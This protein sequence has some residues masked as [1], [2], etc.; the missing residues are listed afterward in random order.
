VRQTILL[1]IIFMTFLFSS[2]KGENFTLIE[3]NRSEIKI[4][5]N[6]GKYE[7]KNINN[8]SIIDASQLVNTHELGLPELPQFSTT[9]QVDPMYNYDVSFNIIESHVLDNI[10]IYPHQGLDPQMLREEVIVDTTYFSNHNIY[11]SEN[12]VVS[13]SQNMRGMS[14]VS[15]TLIPFKYNDANDLI[16]FDNVEIIV[17]QKDRNDNSYSSK[18]ASRV[19]ANLAENLALNSILLEREENYQQPAIL[20]ICGGNSESN[21]SFQQ[22]VNWRHER[23]YIVYT[24]DTNE[25]GTSSFT[26]KNYIQNAYETFSPPPEYVCL[27][28]DVGGSYSL[29]TFYASWGHDYYGDWCEGDLS[30][31]QL[32]GPDLLPEVIVGRLS[33]RSSNDIQNVVNKIINYEKAT[34]FDYMADYYERSALIGDPSDSGQSTIITNEYVEDV[35]SSHGMSDIRTNFGV[36]NYA[37]WMQNQLSDGVLYFNYRGFAGVSGFTSANIY[38]ANSGHKLPFATVLT[39]LT[40]SFAEET[41]CLS[42]Y[43]LRAGSG[44]NPKGA[45]AAVSTATGNTHTMFNNIVDMGIYDG[46]FANQVGTA[47]AALANGKL[48]LLNAYPD[49]PDNWINAFT[50]WNNLMGDPAT[51]LWTDTPDAIEVVH[52]NE[53]PFGESEIHISILHHSP[54]FVTLT[55]GDEIFTSKYSQLIDNQIASFDIDYITTGEITITV[56][57]ENVI[58]YQSIINIVQAENYVDIDSASEILIEDGNDGTLNPGETFTLMVPVMNY[59]TQI[60]NNVNVQIIAYDE[61]LVLL[62]PN[63]SN[64]GSIEPNSMSYGS[65]FDF[66]LLPNLMHGENVY[67]EVEITD[68]FGIYNSSLIYLDVF[69]VALKPSTELVLDMETSYFKIPLMNLGAVESVEVTATLSCLNENIVIENAISSWD[70]ILP[71]EI[72]DSNSEFAISTQGNIINGSF[73]SFA[74]EIMAENGYHQNESFS[75]Q[76]GESLVTDPLGPDEYGYYIYDMGDTNYDLAPTYNWVE[77]STNEGGNGTPLN[78]SDNGNGIYSNSSEI[79]DLPFS[80]QFYG[81]DYDKITVCTNGWIAF[82]ESNLE[83]FRNYPVPGAGG[84]SAMIAAFW[85]D[86]YTT[87]NADVFVYHDMLNDDFIIEWYRMKNFME[88]D[89]QTFQIILHQNIDSNIDNN[90]TIQYQTFNN[91]STGDYYSYTPKHGAYSTIGIENH[92]SE[93][94]L[95]YSFYNEYPQSAMQLGNETAIFITTQ[96]PDILPIPNCEVDVNEINLNMSQNEEEE[97]SITITNA[98]DPESIL[99][100]SINTRVDIVVSPFDVT[101]GGPDAYGY[102]WSDS[103]LDSNIDFEW[104]DIESS[105]TEIV[106]ETN[107]NATPPIDIGF[108]FP[109]YG[110]LYSQIIVNPNGWIGFGSDNDAWYNIPIPSTNAPYPAIMGYWDD[111]NPENQSNSSGDGNVYYNANNERLVVWF[112]DVIHYPGDYDGTF[113]FQMVIFPNGDIHVNYFSVWGYTTLSTIGIQNEMGQAGLQVVYNAEYVDNQFSLQFKQADLLSEWLVL[114]NGSDILSGQLQWDESLQFQVIA[115]STSLEVGEYLSYIDIHSDGQET[116][117]VP[118]TMNVSNSDI[119]AISLL[120]GWNLLSF[121]VESGNMNLM[122]IIQPL[123]DANLLVKIMNESGESIENIGEPIGWINQIG[124]MSVSEGYKI[125]VNNDVD[126]IVYGQFVQNPISIDIISDWNIIGYPST[127]NQNAI[128]LLQPL[129]DSGVLVKVLDESGNSIEDLGFPIGWINQIGDFEMGEGYKIK[130]SESSSLIIE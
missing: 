3:Q 13:E 40:G 112:D 87:G 107:D 25:T 101:G 110:E 81:E 46:I 111:L 120:N 127:N 47:G 5:F 113:N 28:G 53:I 122:S 117:S 67:I 102:F 79:I 108:E 17:N 92:L 95:Q 63:E 84:P 54:V 80:F 68:E 60:S 29:P 44:S 8:Y 106:F 31:S 20:Y 118:V 41:T 124:D 26:I 33:V 11:P 18:P 96:L 48:A 43:F 76:F 30:Y 6:L 16:I 89:L 94:G 109:F 55:K 2:V 65:G 1:L 75:I 14:F 70:S 34:Y 19:F 7:V 57:G 91:T 114:D 90:V 116:V 130:V 72:V 74:L 73:I 36:G 37:N 42:E 93:I 66:E 4:Q 104:I 99:D 82:G 115:N 64:Y 21:P 12:I 49:N 15:I 129:I 58:P 39:C 71:G 69:G 125:K 128:D 103:N 61:S 52:P 121:A 77:I 85:D 78:L 24:A 59:G 9:V 119:Q 88:N 22:L 45:V 98:G 35:M 126:L 10:S 50:Q 23:G 62:N 32:D 51:H 27:V 86:L 56:V 97:V 83:S 123:I 38:N 100:Y 105:N